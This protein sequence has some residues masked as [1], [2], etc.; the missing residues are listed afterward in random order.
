MTL[1][2]LTA[3]LALGDV[4]LQALVPTSGLAAE[5]VLDGKAD[6]SWTPEGSPVGE[7]ILFRFE[8]PA[9]VKSVEVTFCP[10]D[11]SQ[12]GA[13]FDG[14][15]DRETFRPDKSGKAKVTPSFDFR[16]LF[17]KVESGKGCV[18]EVNFVTPAGTVK[19][20]RTVHG[21]V[22]VSS[23]LTPADAYHPGYLFDGRTDFGWVEGS[24][25]T[26]EKE[27]LELGLD[28]P[29]TV[30]AIEVWNGYQRSPDHFKK[31][32]RPK[33]VTLQADGG[34]GVALELKDSGDGP[35]KLVLPKPMK[36]QAFKLTIDSVVKG[37]RYTDLVISEL[38]LHD[39][40]GPLQIATDDVKER[41]AVLKAELAGKPLGALLDRQLVGFCSPDALSVKLRS[42]HTFAIYQT[43]GDAM[44]TVT[45][46]VD[47]AWIVKSPTSIELFGRRQTVTVDDYPYGRSGTKET[48]RITGGAVTVT[49]AKELDA[50]GY[51]KLVA[52]W[53]GPAASQLCTAPDQ[54]ASLKDAVV[55]EGVALTGLVTPK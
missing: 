8:A 27:W 37:T 28:A 15:K 51:A 26:G 14:R 45:E 50:D 10:G 11:A 25:G 19:A 5:N 21:K 49:P 42:N 18:A 13:F 40:T 44:T 47:G 54:L 55:F 32:C 34:E 12:L 30:T 39:E 22:T 24:K 6:T 29:V 17:L 48:V 43:A 38:R 36:G 33:K 23:V 2:A 46:V 4:Y 9:G 35:Q 7:G 53:S 20:P 31:N 3:A 1:L 41:T 52:K 16:S